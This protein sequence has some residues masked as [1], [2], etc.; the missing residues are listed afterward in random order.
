V[1]DR[2]PVSSFRQA[3]STR[4]EQRRQAQVAEAGGQDERASEPQ[5]QC[6]KGV[7]TD[8]SQRYEGNTRMAVRRSQR[9]FR[10]TRSIGEVVS[11]V[12]CSK[13][14]KGRR[15]ADERREL[16]NSQDMERGLETT[17]WWNRQLCWMRWVGGMGEDL[18][19]AFDDPSPSLPPMRTCPGSSWSREPAHGRGTPASNQLR[20]ATIWQSVCMALAE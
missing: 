13:W 1:D 16:S 15:R 12:K 10:N 17:G 6:P 5:T 14:E 19:S 4:N 18:L 8:L 2:D 11:V 7:G 9:V 20:D 3:G